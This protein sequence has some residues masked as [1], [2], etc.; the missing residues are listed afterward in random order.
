MLQVQTQAGKTCGA[1]CNFELLPYYREA[2]CDLELNA[3]VIAR[4]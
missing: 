1:N 4:P 2:G 3:V